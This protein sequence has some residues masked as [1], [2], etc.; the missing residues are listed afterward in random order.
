MNTNKTLGQAWKDFIGLVYDGQVCLATFLEEKL[1]PL[2]TPDDQTWWDYRVIRQLTPLQRSNIEKEG[3]SKLDLAGLLNVLIGNWKDISDTQKGFPLAHQMQ[4]IREVLAHLTTEGI[5][6]L[7]VE[8]IYRHLDTLERFLKVIESDEELIQRVRK[9]KFDI[10]PLLLDQELPRDPLS[11][12]L[13]QG[14]EL[15]RG[16]TGDKG[17][18]SSAPTAETIQSTPVAP[19]T[20]VSQDDT[21]PNTVQHAP[22]IGDH[23]KGIPPTPDDTKVYFDRGLP[24]RSDEQ[25]EAACKA[26]DA[27]IDKNPDADAYNNCGIVK[28]SHQQYEEAKGDFERAISLNSDYFP[29]Y[30]NRAYAQIQLGHYEAAIRSCVEALKQNRDYAPAYTNRGSARRNLGQYGKAIKDYDEALRIDPYFAP[31]Y[32]GRGLAKKRFRA[33]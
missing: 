33:V 28:L 29:A 25:Y 7:P 32:N 26:C 18:F 19:K 30:T 23:G 14:A 11:A 20:G 5:K 4:E 21:T 22:V 12:D 17:E 24:R 13:T 6:E 9:S 15:S 1:P 3:I 10:V 8:D 27:A 31:A 2:Y 16:E